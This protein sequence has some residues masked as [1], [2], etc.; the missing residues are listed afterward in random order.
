MTTHDSTSDAPEAGPGVRAMKIY[1]PRRFPMDQWP[2]W[3]DQ[4]TSLAAAAYPDNASVARGLAGDL[5]DLITVSKAPPGTPLIALLSEQNIG[6]VAL[7]RKRRRMDA[8]GINAGT[9]R[10]R[11]LR[12]TSLDMPP[13]APQP[14][15]TTMFRRQI[16]DLTVLAV[17]AED[18]VAQLAAILY[19]ALLGPG[20]IPVDCPITEVDFKQFAAHA[21]ALGYGQWRWRWR[22]LRTEA[23]RWRFTQNRS[24]MDVLADLDVPAKSLDIVASVDWRAEFSDV[25]AVRG[26]GNVNAPCRW[27]VVSESM[28]TPLAKPQPQPQRRRISKA[29][30]KR[31]TA[32]LVEAR[33][34]AAAPLSDNLEVILA[35]WEPRADLLDPHLWPAVR[36]L[37]RDIMR[38]S[39]FRGPENFTK[40]LRSITVHLGWCY[41]QGYEMDIDSVLATSAI[42]Q[43]VTHMRLTYKDSSV[44]K[45]RSQ[46]TSIAKQVSLSPDAPVKGQ[47]IEHWSVKPPYTEAEVRA[48]LRR[49]DLLVDAKTRAALQTAV[50]LGLGAGLDT[51]DI[52]DMTRAHISDLDDQG[53]CVDVPGTRPRRVWLRHEYEDLLRTGIAGLTRNEPVLG[54]RMHKDS[55]RDLYKSIQPIGD[56]PIIQQGRLR[57]TWIATLMME[58]I[59]LWTVLKAAGLTGAR[60]L[61]DIAQFITPVEDERGTRG[62]A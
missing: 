47:K 2:A 58:P 12:D 24:V 13:A 19:E 42:N 44:A 57:N 34:S 40:A 33:D 30:I 20:P 8:G 1:K 10:L 28:S 21:R 32:A 62:A 17:F 43:H 56:G 55:V 61:A 48:I 3:W 39:H 4:V 14:R 52:A 29:E 35:T 18:N 5:C 26:C 23:M 7:D 41:R 6:L 9:T 54:R 11:R 22:D 51:R 27:K 16:A 49:L 38:R 59:A 31:R 46:L 50:T 36:D 15:A 60:T 37:A 45:M 25:T 53:I